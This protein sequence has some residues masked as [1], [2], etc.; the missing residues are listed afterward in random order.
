MTLEH[1]EREILIPKK[2]PFPIGQAEVKY[3][4]QY[5]QFRGGFVPED[6][7][8]LVSEPPLQGRGQLQFSPAQW[9]RIIQAMEPPPHVPPLEEQWKS[10]WT[11]KPHPVLSEKELLEAQRLMRL[12]EEAAKAEE[13]RD[14]AEMA[15]I[16]AEKKQQQWEQIQRA[17]EMLRRQDER[18]TQ[19][20]QAL[21]QS[22]VRCVL[23]FG[24]Y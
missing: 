2:I 23:I 8:P 10:A 12:K 1:I 24:E 16:R 20:H 14:E 13:A 4:E 19:I 22:E 5:H 3:S 18:H 15:K 17:K 11:K 6:R 9:N 7:Y 21:L